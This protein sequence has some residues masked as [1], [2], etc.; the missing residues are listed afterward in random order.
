MSIDSQVHQAFDKFNKWETYGRVF[1]LMDKRKITLRQIIQIAR[2]YGISQGVV[3]MRRR[4][5]LA[6]M[7]F[8]S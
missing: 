6:H 7:R 5:Y 1:Q 2:Q 8:Y 4:D 3:E